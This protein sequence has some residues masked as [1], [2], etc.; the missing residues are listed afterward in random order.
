MLN[1]YSRLSYSVLT[2]FYT[3][4]K[5]I[6][7]FSSILKKYEKIKFYK[8]YELLQDKLNCSSITVWLCGTKTY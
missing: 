1:N 7:G 3:F 8:K 6:D 2:N 5:I 4:C